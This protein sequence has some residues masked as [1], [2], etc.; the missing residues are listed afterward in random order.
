MATTHGVKNT[1]ASRVAGNV[2]DNDA[3]V[4]DPVKA[5]A[6]YNATEQAYADGDRADLQADE[7]GFLKT[8]DV[9]HEITVFASAARAEGDSPFTSAD[10]INRYGRGVVLYLDITD[11]SGT[12]PTLDIKV[13]GK[14][15]VSGK[16][17]DIA[18]GAFAQQTGTGTVVLTIYPGIAETANVSAS[19]VIPT[20]WRVHVTVGSGGA[21]G[22][23]TFSIGASYIR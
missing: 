10:L 18:D 23:F 20:T 2:P 16:Y 4:G 3:D 12:S 22:S 14:D 21:D 7:R 15:P 6:R 13:Q 1:S 8:A 19:D 5:G 17:F 11:A 9:N